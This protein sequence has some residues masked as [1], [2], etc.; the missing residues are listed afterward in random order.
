MVLGKLEQFH[1]ENLTWERAL[2]F[3]KQENSFLKTRLSQVLDNNSPAVEEFI[4]LVEQFQNQFILKDEFIAELMHDIHEQEEKLKQNFIAPETNGLMN[5][6]LTK[7]QEKLRN[8]MI[9]F[10]KDFARLKNE[11]NNYLVQVL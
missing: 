4:S 7:Q 10:E 2:E 1:H 6:K 11:F 3:F 8:E 5:K 9:F